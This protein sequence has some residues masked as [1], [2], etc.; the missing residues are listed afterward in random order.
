MAIFMAQSMI[1]LS[2]VEN[3]WMFLFIPLGFNIFYPLKSGKNLFHPDLCTLSITIWSF[4][5]GQ[6]M[7]HCTHLDCV[8][9]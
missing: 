2:Q 3:I 9:N 4:S 5:S 6:S 1:F 7:H 8:E